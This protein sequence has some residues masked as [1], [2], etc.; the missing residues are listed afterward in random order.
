MDK[1]L[2]EN[3]TASSFGGAVPAHATAG[4]DGV[5]GFPE[6]T[7]ALAEN[8]TLPAGAGGNP[9][10]DGGNTF[11]EEEEADLDDYNMHGGVGGGLDDAA[12]R[13]NSI[14]VQIDP[15]LAE[16]SVSNAAP[17]NS[18][19]PAVAAPPPLPPA[20]A[21]TAGIDRSGVCADGADESEFQLHSDMSS[22]V[23]CGCG[24]RRGEAA[25]GT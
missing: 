6:V 21:A 4:D 11:T 14:I 1:A 10:L 22:P 9:L 20:A 3:S 19:A 5:G 24:R 17:K 7:P 15:M 25:S 2:V 23:G 18:S 12:V 8:A 16:S 13:A